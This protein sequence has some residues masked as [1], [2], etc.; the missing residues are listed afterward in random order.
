MSVVLQHTVVDD[1][2]SWRR[3]KRATTKSRDKYLNNII[4]ELQEKQNNEMRAFD[5]LFATP[6]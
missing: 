3:T 6:R 4:H 2:H 5:D 1:K